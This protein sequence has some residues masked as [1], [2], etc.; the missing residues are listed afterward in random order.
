[1]RV[2]T[3]NCWGL[4]DAITAIVYRK[5]KRTKP[6]RTERMKLIGKELENF[7]VVCLQEMWMKE[8]QLMLQQMGKDAGLNYSH[9]YASGLIN[10]A[11]LQIIS[12]YPISEVHFHKYRVNGNILRVDHGDHHAGKGIGYAKIKLDENT[13]ISVFN[14]H[15]IAAYS[16]DDIYHTDRLSQVW[17]LA[18]FVQMTTAHDDSSLVL[19]TGDFNC[20][21]HSLEYQV[22]LK[23]S[24]LV[25]AY[26]FLHMDEGYTHED[27]G[28]GKP[29]KLDYIFFNKNKRWNLRTTEVTL[30]NHVKFYSDH[31]GILAHFQLLEDGKKEI[32]SGNSPTMQSS[33]DSILFQVHKRIID[34]IALASRRRMVHIKTGLL[35]LFMLVLLKV[36][37]MIPTFLSDAMLVGLLVQLMIPLFV[38]GNDISALK[39]IADEIHYFLP[40]N[41]DRRMDD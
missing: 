1:L 29:K 22:F 38:E 35:I 21:P 30:K 28:D 18:R 19:V 41:D 23:V 32:Q 6:K 20:G 11:G 9:V 26:T 2:L 40:P 3:L 5:M 16:H 15:T 4:P 34:G 36:Y 31:F 39:Q 17:E 12:R 25:D 7:D 13:T 27:L 33:S 8:D 37:L 24:N 10:S 14:T